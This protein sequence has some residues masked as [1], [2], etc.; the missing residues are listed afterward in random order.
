MT[1]KLLIKNSGQTTLLPEVQVVDLPAF[2]RG[3]RET[4]F[5][6][7]VRLTLITSDSPSLQPRS[8]NLAQVAE[9]EI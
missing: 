1:Q 3:S 2:S 6:E 9:M 5:F 4:E 7:L 8:D